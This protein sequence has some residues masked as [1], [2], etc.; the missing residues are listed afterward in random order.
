[1]HNPEFYAGDCRRQVEEFLTGFV[2]PEEPASLH[3]AVAPH[4]GWAYSG[5][6]AARAWRALA[7]RAR[8]ETV[9]IFGAVHVPG[10]T[11]NSVWSGGPWETPLGDVEVD[12]ELVARILGEVKSLAIADTSAHLQDHSIEVQLPFLKALL[13][14]SKVVPIA[15][16][17]HANPVQLGDLLG[18]LTRGRPIAAVGSSDLTHYGEERFAFAPRGTGPAAHQWMKENDQRVLGL[19]EGLLAEEIGP[20]VAAHRNACGPGALAATAAFAR[21]RGAEAGI[22]LE[23][24]TSHEVRPEEPFRFGVGYAGMIF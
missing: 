9:I 18:H 12:S 20:E 17:P 16:P 24:T 2:P 19:M 15:V 21:A 14:K 23:H 10:V 6:L 22:L 1:M 7:E 8:P 13:P 3:G 5:R 11:E 4:A